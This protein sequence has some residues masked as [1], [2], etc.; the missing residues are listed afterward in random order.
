M[1]SSEDHVVEFE[2]ENEENPSEKENEDLEDFQLGSPVVCQPDEQGILRFLRK[3]RKKTAAKGLGKKT[4]KSDS[5]SDFDSENDGFSSQ[6]GECCLSVD[7]ISV[8]L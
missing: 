2:L 1:S 7:P 5:D 4:R 6:K 3:K 8:D